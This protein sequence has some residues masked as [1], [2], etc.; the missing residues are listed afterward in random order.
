MAWKNM[1]MDLAIPGLLYDHFRPMELHQ[2]SGNFIHFLDAMS[3][4][5]LWQ[6]VPM[7]ACRQWLC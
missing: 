2:I 1:K 6:Q 4:T 5:R 3:L 7:D